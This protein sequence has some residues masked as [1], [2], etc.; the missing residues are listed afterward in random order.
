MAGCTLVG[1]PTYMTVCVS[2]PVCFST[3]E[4]AIA[5]NGSTIMEFLFEYNSQ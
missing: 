5:L 2:F 1:P 4:E 3:F